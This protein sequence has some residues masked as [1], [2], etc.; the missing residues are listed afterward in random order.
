M[1]IDKFRELASVVEA[2]IAV[3]SSYA[4][5][6]MDNIRPS[7]VWTA[8]EMDAGSS[9]PCDVLLKGCYGAAVEAVSLVSFGLVRPAMLSL[10]SHYEF[11]LQ[12]LFYKDHPV[13][14]RNVSEFRCQP[15]LPGAVKKYLRYNFPKFEDRFRK[16]LSVKGRSTEDCYEVLSGIAHGTAINSISSATE[17]EDLVESE[18]V[19]SQSVSVFQS[20][21]EHICDIYVSSFE[22]NWLSLP[23]L[24]RSDLV[25]RFGAKNAKNELRL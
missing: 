10:R 25:A 23:K 6:C 4:N 15:N 21:G 14:W 8:R 24:T 2:Q 11:S 5:K 9:S 20:V 16:L 22:S 3:S 7:L 18:D 1:S 19:I 12:Y 13:E 17:P